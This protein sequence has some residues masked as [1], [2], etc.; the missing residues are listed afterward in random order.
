M[1]NGDAARPWRSHGRRGRQILSNPGSA[2]WRGAS[3]PAAAGVASAVSANGASVDPGS[4][5]GAAVSATAGA[6][7]CPA[8]LRSRSTSRIP[9]STLF[10]AVST[11]CFN[12]CAVDCISFCSLRSSSSSSSRLMSALTSPT[13]R[14]S[15]PNSTPS[16]RAV[17]GSFSGPITTS[18][19][20]AM[21]TISENPTSNMDGR[22]R[23]AYDFVVSRLTSPSIVVP[24]SCARRAASSASRAA[25]VASSFMPSLKPFTAPPRSWPML[26]SFFVPKIIT[27]TR[28]TIN[29]CQMLIE[30]ISISLSAPARQHRPQRF[31]ASQHVQVNV[32]HFLQ[33]DASVVDDEAEA[34]AG[35]LVERELAG[36]PHHA[37]HHRRVAIGEVVHRCH[38]RL[39]D[40]QEVH[41]SLRPDVAEDQDAVVLVHLAA[42]NLT[43]DDPAEDA[44]RV[45][46]RASF[47]RPARRGARGGAR[48]LYCKGCQ[49]VIPA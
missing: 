6:A 30:P 45:L 32:L 40:H 11:D 34:V 14:C 17:F 46:H 28:R 38:V 41:G 3:A 44:I 33:P 9:D 21:T 7:S 25:V 36:E 22:P 26:R 31:G 4:A 8:A 18:A 20:T 27:T 47:P 13:Y 19:T 23:D 5:T 49:P 1:I 39:R 10:A 35:A 43:L 29:Q 42:G 15:R 37:S 48:S 2:G 24:P 16:V 12:S